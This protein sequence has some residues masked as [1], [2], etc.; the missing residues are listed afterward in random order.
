[1]TSFSTIS[2]APPSSLYQF[3]VDPVISSFSKV[4]N[5]IDEHEYKSVV[6]FASITIDQINRSL[7]YSVLDHRIHAL[8]NMYNY[9]AAIRDAKHMVSIAPSSPL[10][11]LRLGNLYTIQGKQKEAIKTYETALRN[12]SSPPPLKNNSN[13][14]DIIHYQQQEQYQTLIQRKKTA[15]E[16]YRKRI[17]FIS[18]LPKEL[19]FSILAQLNKESK[20][21]CLETCKKWCEILLECPMAWYTVNM[22]NSNFIL[23]AHIESM[24]P[25]IAPN[26]RYL[27]LDTVGKM[28]GSRFIDEMSN[29]TFRNIRSLRIT[30][31]YIYNRNFSFVI[32]W[33]K[34]ISPRKKTY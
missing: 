18:M 8:C 33:G 26:V 21:A 34:G 30:G 7:L 23:E 9:E 31:I 24:V 2:S 6:D 1:M 17:D 29:G 11:Y 27:S 5:A 10:S 13:D 3:N 15:M 19:S 4:S 14:A 16:Q 32:D 28:A 22:N 25:D 20:S 12:I